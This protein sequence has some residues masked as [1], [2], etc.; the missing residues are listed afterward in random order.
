M[1]SKQSEFTV[2]RMY[3]GQQDDSKLLVGKSGP[4]SY[5]QMALP[6]IP[7]RH[8]GYSRLLHGCSFSWYTTINTAAALLLFFYITVL[9]L[10]VAWHMCSRHCSHPAFKETIA[11]FASCKYMLA[12]CTLKT[13]QSL[14]TCIY[15][16]IR[17]RHFS[18]C[19]WV[20]HCVSEV[21]CSGSKW[22]Q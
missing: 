22:V 21:W 3:A 5:V 4:Y 13:L 6:S 18:Q 12:I 8:D 10:N 14:V 2:R 7:L 19:A 17:L 11:H 9:R 16:Y 1:S 20:P 15:V